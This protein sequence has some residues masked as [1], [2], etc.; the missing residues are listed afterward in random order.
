MV[1]LGREEFRVTAL[2]LILLIPDFGYI[3]FL[4]DQ[5]DGARSYSSD[6]IYTL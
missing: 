5:L 6:L 4:V 2:I 1:N 3:A